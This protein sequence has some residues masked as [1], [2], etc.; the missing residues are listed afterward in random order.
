VKN[1]TCD[2]PGIQSGPEDWDVPCLV[3][4]VALVPVLQSLE[5][6]VVSLGKVSLYLSSSEVKALWGFFLW[7]QSRVFISSADL[8]VEHP[9]TSSLALSVAACGTLG[10]LFPSEGLNFPRGRG[11]SYVALENLSRADT[12]GL[13]RDKVD[14]DFSMRAQ[15]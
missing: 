2:S 1:G 11:S 3:C 5:S 15:F 9:G 6:L 8:E 12:L 14:D 4:S 13:G 10:N 7:G